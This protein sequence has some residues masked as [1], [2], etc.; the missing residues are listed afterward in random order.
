MSPC[1]Q[2]ADSKDL[3]VIK[4]C[5]GLIKPCSFEPGGLEQ[6]REGHYISGPCFG[7]G[8]WWRLYWNLSSIPFGKGCFGPI[9]DIWPDHV[10]HQGGK[11][12]LLTY[13]L[14]CFLEG[15]SSSEVIRRRY[16]GFQCVLQ[17]L[18]VWDLMTLPYFWRLLDAASKKQKCHFS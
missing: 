8:L 2:Q 18:V 12:Q 14:K 3:L 9:R 5:W 11:H 16:V 15:I 6:G 4:L 1:S 10:S 13:S 17:I 7:A